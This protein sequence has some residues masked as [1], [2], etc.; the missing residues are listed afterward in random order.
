[1]RSIS[2]N[3]GALVFFGVGYDDGRVGDRANAVVP[4]LF[5]FRT[6]RL[7]EDIAVGVG[8]VLG[9]LVFLGTVDVFVAGY[10]DHV[11]VG[12][13]DEAAVAAGG[14]SFSGCGSVFDE[15]N[16]SGESGAGHGHDQGDGQNGSDDFV[17][18]THDEFL[19]FNII[20]VF[21]D[22]ALMRIISAAASVCP[23]SSSTDK[24]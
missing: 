12:A 19:L 2:G 11:V 15:L 7:E 17:E 6:G 13:F 10:A 14:V 22:W 18:S 1:M 3:V 24:D 8:V 4:G 21:G 20:K 5:G 9:N 16:L 23:C